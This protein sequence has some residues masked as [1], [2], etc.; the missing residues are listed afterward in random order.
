MLWDL[1][2]CH[3]SED[4]EIARPL[5]DALRAR[6][7]RVWFD[8]FTLTVGDGL[9][10]SI[11]YGLAH[12]KFGV[13]I[14]SPSFFG[15]EWPRREL[16]GLSAK[17]VSSGKTILPVWHNVNRDYVLEYSPVL[18]DKLAVSTKL[19]LSKVVDEILRAVD[20]SVREAT[21]SESLVA[22]P[23]SEKVISWKGLTWTALAL[24]LAVGA[25]LIYANQLSLALHQVDP[26]LTG[27]SAIVTTTL[28]LA[29]SEVAMK[30]RKKSSNQS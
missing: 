11:D 24:A 26:M 23:R 6:G 14:L 21:K 10:R 3:A 4:N 1:F 2:I 20:Q 18:A 28:V 12:S 16:D 7:L 30:H 29:V 17:E 22:S 25:S 5:T 9:S 27:L 8:E 13:V 15:K 19:G